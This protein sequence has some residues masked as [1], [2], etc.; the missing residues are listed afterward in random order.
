MHVARNISHII[1]VSNRKNICEDFRAV[2]HAD[3][4]QSGKTALETFVTSGNQLIQKLL[5]LYMRTL[6]Y[7]HITAFLSQFGEASIQRTS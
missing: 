5:N 6:I 3:D 2:Y 7:S 1:R 4:E